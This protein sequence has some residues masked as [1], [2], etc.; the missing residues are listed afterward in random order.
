MPRRMPKRTVRDIFP[1][2]IDE[3]DGTTSCCTT[4]TRPVRVSDMGRLA[5]NTNESAFCLPPLFGPLIFDNESSDCRDHCANERTFLSYLRLSIYMAIVSV[6][7][8][9]SFHLRK[10]ASD[11]E[12]RMAMPLGGIF[13][14]LSVACLGV[15]VSNYINTVNKYSRRAAIVQTGWKTQTVFLPFQ[16]TFSSEANSLQVMAIIALCIIASCVTLLVINRI[17]EGSDSGA[18]TQRFNPF[19]L[20]NPRKGVSL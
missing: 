4:L 10:T 3:E 12:L 16:V 14:V 20:I 17:N 15:G 19:A 5:P 18:N 9:L 2:E 13:W 7:I 8:V 1:N 6:A 11:I